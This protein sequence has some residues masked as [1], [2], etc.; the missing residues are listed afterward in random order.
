MNRRRGAWAAAAELRNFNPFL[1]NLD[2]IA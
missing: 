2:E 1:L